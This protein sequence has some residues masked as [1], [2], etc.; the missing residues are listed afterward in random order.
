MGECRYLVIFYGVSA[1]QNGSNMGADEQD[2]VMLVYLVLN[3]EE[4]KVGL[5]N[6]DIW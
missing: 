4:N 1:G 6:K 3:V 2:L 5:L